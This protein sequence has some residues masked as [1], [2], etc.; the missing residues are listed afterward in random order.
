MNCS[1]LCA[2]L[3]PVSGLHRFHS[4][5]HGL[6]QHRLVKGRRERKSQRCDKAPAMTVVKGLQHSDLLLI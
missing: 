2:S 6:A 4:N 5:M 1:L 3:G